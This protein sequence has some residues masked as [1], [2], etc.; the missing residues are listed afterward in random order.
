M[1]VCE[2]RAAAPNRPFFSD[3]HGNLQVAA[4]EG[5]VGLELDNASP[6][7]FLRRL[8]ILEII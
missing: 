1:P 3:C 5:E 4:T 8:L 7:V 2:A 6:L